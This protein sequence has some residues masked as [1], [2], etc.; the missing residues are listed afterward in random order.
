MDL[1]RL[2]SPGAQ[3]ALLASLAVGRAFVLSQPPRDQLSPAFSGP[4]C[5][6]LWIPRGGF[7]DRSLRCPSD[8][9]YALAVP[10]G[11]VLYC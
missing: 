1:L 9:S 10:L 5:V 6:S 4:A 11:D 3:R 8:L 7:G 2:T